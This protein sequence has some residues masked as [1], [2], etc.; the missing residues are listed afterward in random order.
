MTEETLAK[1]KWSTREERRTYW[2]EHIEKWQQSGQSK[3]AYC[4]EHG[5]KT[6]N[7]YR[8]CAKLLKGEQRRPQFIP[9]RLP[10][11]PANRYAIELMLV[12]GRILHIG[13]DVD[14]VWVSQLVQELERAC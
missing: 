13:D 7:L 2:R 8:W 4:R 9:V 1:I 3:R 14:P 10:S 6:A 12:N 5:L 11:I